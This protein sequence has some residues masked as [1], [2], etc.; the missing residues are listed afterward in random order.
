MKKTLILTALALALTACGGD[1]EKTHAVDVVETAEQ[2]AKA[3]APVA[4]PIKFDD[5]KS[6]TTAPATE[7]TAE[8]TETGEA[9]EV[10]VDTKA[11]TKAEEK[12][13][14][15]AEE[16]PATDEKADKKAE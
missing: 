11:E 5:E 10:E 9:K 13:E 6:A 14:A 15:K 16:K 3:V 12:P 2:N 4:E 8:A 1:H 7:P